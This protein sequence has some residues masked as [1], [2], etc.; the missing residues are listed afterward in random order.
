MALTLLVLLN[1]AICLSFSNEILKENIHLV[2]N[3]NYQSIIQRLQYANIYNDVK[4]I[5][6]CFTG[7][8]N[9]VYIIIAP[10]SKQLF[11]LRV[12]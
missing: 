8:Y 4:N 10:S 11:L 12:C 5:S 3:F 6:W 7:I 2:L 1:I 9:D